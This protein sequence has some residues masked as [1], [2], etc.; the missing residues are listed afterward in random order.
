MDYQ[1]ELKRLQESGNYWKPKV[2]QYKVKA[3]TEL[4]SAEP[5]IRKSKN[6]KGEEVV[7][8][9]PQ[10]KIQIL[11]DGDEEKTWTFGIGKTPA[12]TYG[13]LVDLATKHANQLKE[14]EFSVVVKSDG[15]K[16]DYTIVN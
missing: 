11:V 10:A 7:E 3:L 13:Q 16:N 14:V 8:E 1:K 15:T 6:D 2:G 9:S 5:Y 4:E 12:S